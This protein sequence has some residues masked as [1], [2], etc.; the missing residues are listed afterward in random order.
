MRLEALIEM[1]IVM[2]RDCGRA[3]AEIVLEEPDFNELGYDL[4]L[5]QAPYS[6]LSYQAIILRD[7][8]RVKIQR[9]PDDF[10]F[11]G[12]CGR[13]IIRK[14]KPDQQLFQ[15]GDEG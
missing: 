1:L 5:K 8:T 12:P 14:A 3:P 10:V 6:T 15:G 9:L 13:T 7:G 11:A 4:K 2:A